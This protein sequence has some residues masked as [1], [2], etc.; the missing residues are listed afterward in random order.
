MKKCILFVDDEPLALQGLQRMLRSMRGD[1][2]MLFAESGARGLEVMSGQFF[3]VVVSDMLMPGMNG[4]A[5]LSEVRMRH[6]GVVRLVLSGHAQRDLVMASVGPAHQYLAKPCHPETLK[7]AVTRASSL[8]STLN[9]EPIRQFVLQMDRLPSV[10]SLYDE[11][12]TTLQA[13]E[14]SAATVA[15]IMGRDPGMTLKILKMVNSAFFGFYGQVSSVADA[16]SYLGLDT[17]KSLALSINGFS[18]FESCHFHEHGLD[19]LWNH[20]LNTALA[21]KLIAVSEN[22]EKKTID[23]AFTAGLLHDLGKFVLI[24][25]LGAQ[26]HEAVQ[27]AIEQNVELSAA[28]QQI[29]GVSHEDVGAYLGG[30]W[31]LPTPVLDAIS[32]HQNPRKAPSKDFTPLTAVHVAH[33]L[34]QRPNGA[35]NGVPAAQLDL[36]YLTE[37]GMVERLQTWRTAVDEGLS[38]PHNYER[39]NPMR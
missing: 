10:P 4:A 9:S 39:E 35:G 33:A 16:V 17:I 30:L 8:S 31:G 38:L 34:V 18:K 28:E 15:E 37:L 26:Y 22:A 24:S 13:P 27:M 6:P 19:S 21:A 3:D 2:D 12:I 11:L 20:S 29:F 23:A 1:W 14:V 32:G 25:H 36:D 7:T 5:F